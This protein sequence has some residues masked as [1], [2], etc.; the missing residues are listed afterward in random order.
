M[1]DLKKRHK[2]FAIDVATLLQQLP[3]SLV[4]RAYSDQLIRSSSSPG[5]NYRAACRG[6]STADFINK[7]KIVE[8]ELDESVYFLELLHHFNPDIRHVIDDLIKEGNGLLAITIT[9]IKTA[10]S[11][12]GTRD[13]VQGTR[14]KGR[15]T[16]D[17]GRGTRDEVE[18]R[19]RMK[20]G[21]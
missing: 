1:Q 2:Q 18:G 5:T 12:Q 4:N 8:E 11:R 14:Y 10:R 13:E 9:S 19:R 16:R 6:K 21:K 3:K 20:E 15:G 7:L 17:E